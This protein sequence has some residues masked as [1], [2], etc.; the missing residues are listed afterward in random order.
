MLVCFIRF[1]QS[2]ER[3]LAI[4]LMAFLILIRI[5]KACENVKILTKTPRSYQT[6]TPTKSLSMVNVGGDN[7]YRNLLNYICIYLYISR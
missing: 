7:K 4:F 2:K 1:L 6:F 5:N 3:I